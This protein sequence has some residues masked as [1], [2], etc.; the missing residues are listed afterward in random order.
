MAPAMFPNG[1]NPFEVDNVLHTLP[2]SGAISLNSAF[3]CT[4]PGGK[5]SKANP[6]IIGTGNTLDSRKTAG[7]VASAAAGGLRCDSREY[8]PLLR[9]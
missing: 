3:Q 7:G 1:Y 6:S 9:H 4:L 5:S 8:V 2:V